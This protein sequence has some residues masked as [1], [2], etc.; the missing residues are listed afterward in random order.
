M[1]NP[2]DVMLLACRKLVFH[3]VQ[4]PAEIPKQVRDDKKVFYLKT[5]NAFIIPYLKS[6][7][8]PGNTTSTAPRYRG[9]E[10]KTSKV[11][12]RANIDLVRE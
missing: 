12:Y 10:Q 9:A 1:L 8:K 7:H 3:L 5:M 4:H 11:I 6:R 2:E